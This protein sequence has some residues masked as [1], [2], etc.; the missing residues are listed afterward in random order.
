V[1][2]KWFEIGSH[3]VPSSDDHVKHRGDCTMDLP[4]DGSYIFSGAGIHGPSS[5]WNLV[6]AL[7]ADRTS[8]GD[9]AALHQSRLADGR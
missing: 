8:G 9:I 4:T 5:A 3:C 6:A 7:S 2:F 1:D